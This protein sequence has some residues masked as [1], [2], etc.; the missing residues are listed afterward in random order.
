MKKI[1]YLL[2]L[3]LVSCNVA[4]AQKIEITPNGIS[5]LKVGG[6]V[7]DMPGK[8]V[9]LYD[10]ITTEVLDDMGDT[11]TCYR[12]VKDGKVVAQVEDFMN[13]G[14]MEAIEIL[15][16]DCVIE[17]ISVGTPVAQLFN[18]PKAK[19][20][21]QGNGEFYFLINDVI[22]KVGD[23][24]EAGRKKLDNAYSKG[25]DATFILSDFDK[26]AVVT[27]IICAGKRS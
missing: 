9:G 19:Q 1:I 26:D 16:P 20:M 24:S 6:K 15:S 5:T 21:L 23:F 27:S 13:A 7:S 4:E 11:Y 3:C 10:E 14:E 18:S 17:G 2:A 22:I 12:F 25:T 8:V